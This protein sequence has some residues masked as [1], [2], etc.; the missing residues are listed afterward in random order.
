MTPLQEV[1]A[2]GERHGFPRLDLS[3]MGQCAT[4]ALG[5]HQRQCDQC[6]VAQT[7]ANACRSRACPFCRQRER[8]EWV[9]TT[10]Q[11]LPPVAYFHVVFTVPAELRKLAAANPAVFDGMLMNSAKQALLTICADP[12]HLGVTPAA[13]AVLHTW[14]QRLRLHPHV[15]VVVSA[16]GL[17]PDGR[18]LHAGDTRAKS[19][20]VP[21]RVLRAHF[22]TVLI[23]QL[24]DAH[25]AGRWTTLPP[26]WRLYH[27]FRH[28]L[29]QLREKSW[30]LHLERPLS[31]PQAL[32]R[33]LA[34][35]VNRVAIAPSRVIA[36]D[37]STVTFTWRDRKN[38]NQLMYETLSAAVFLKRFAQHIPPKGFVRIR[39]W[40]LLSP[41]SRVKRLAQTTIALSH[42]PP[43]AHAV[44]DLPAPASTDDHEL[45][46]RCPVCGLGHL[47]Y[48][49]QRTT[50]P[51]QTQLRTHADHDKHPLDQSA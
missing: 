26:E 46:W 27:A 47:R 2:D 14:D 23:N 33:Y 22:Q 12:R 3:R 45:G 7:V 20:L 11:D 40:G 18:W 39:W 42:A 44:I 30:S 25:R 50:T 29:I 6:G 28:A 51:A 4:G 1:L 37:G 35:Y 38:G 32:V 15:H 41:R 5:T 31:G 34:S 48:A 13:F 24:L 10:E 36:Y 17:T 49:G 16:G 43:A 8:G 21:Q 19:F 9:R